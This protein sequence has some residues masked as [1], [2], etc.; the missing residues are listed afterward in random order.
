MS[1][2]FRSFVEGGG[3]FMWLTSSNRVCDGPMGGCR[4]RN[5]VV[6]TLDE[7]V[8]RGLPRTGWSFCGGRCYCFLVPMLNLTLGAPALDGPGFNMADAR[9][10]ARG[11]DEPFSDVDRLDPED[12]VDDLVTMPLARGLRALI[13]ELVADFRAG[14]VPYRAARAEA[15]RILGLA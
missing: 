3:V 11:A 1:G 12:F 14:R 13:D 2:E 9:N 7:W 15:D 6:A 10:D 5:E 8:R 4:A